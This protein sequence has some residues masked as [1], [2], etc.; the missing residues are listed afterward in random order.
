MAISQSSL[1][2][3]FPGVFH[4]SPS[5]P[6]PPLPSL[7]LVK[8][9][10]V[11]VLRTLNRGVRIQ[12]PRAAREDSMSAIISD[13]ELQKTA[14]Q[15][16]TR[17]PQDGLANRW[18]VIHGRDDWAGLLDPIDPLLRTELIR[19]GEFVQACYDSFDYDKFSRYC[20]SCKY[21]R[22]QFFYSLGM[23]SAGYDVTRYLYATSNVKVP[24]F[25]AKSVMGSRTWSERANWIGYV[26]VSNDET[27]ARLG[28]RD[29]LIAW[30]GT[31]T[32]LEWIHDFMAKM[33]PV[34]S[35]GIPCPDTRVKVETGFVDLYIEK[36]STCRFCK[37][38]AR[39]QVLTEVR[40]LVA[41]YTEAGEE[42]SIT[43]AGHSLGSALAT[44][45]AY[46]IAEMELIKGADGKQ[47]PMAV[48]SYGGPRVGNE[49]FKERCD[50]LGLKVLRVVNVH[51]KVP[52]VPGVLI[53]EHMP[54]FMLR[55]MDGY[56]HVG[57]ELL[58]D[59]K[60][61]PFLKDSLDPSNYH[62]LEAHLHLLD[63]FQGKGRKFAPTTGRDPAL[64][65]KSCD[66]LHEHLMVPPNW[67]QDENK[68]MM[69]SQE[70]RW[71]QPERQK[72]DDHPEDIHHH[73]QQLGLDRFE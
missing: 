44:L 62:N 73:Y 25:F 8:P 40:K 36:D 34:R 20:G 45:N 7:S 56:V 66:F 38:S 27:T 17:Q 16:D 70:G 53:N 24:K 28:R 4:S 13:L 14:E 69:R 46:D 61:S 50:K 63:G 33:Q 23:E 47:V 67:R 26:S 57:V 43:V 29:I 71:A 41:Q 51:D 19:Y 64:V 68:G 22:R 18:R 42:V 58:L 65:N 37:Y 72:I 15:V 11:P 9:S 49:H 54:E 35:A 21:S 55:A 39:E 60:H 6:G 10:P 30:R 3:W 2:V 12:P 5:Q 48:F 32:R 31:V 59:H 52:T 1:P